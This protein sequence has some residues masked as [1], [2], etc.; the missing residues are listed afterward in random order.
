MKIV[1]IKQIQLKIACARTGNLATL[2]AE[3]LTIELQEICLLLHRRSH[4]RV[5]TS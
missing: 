3:L 2:N 5:K 4:S 1:F